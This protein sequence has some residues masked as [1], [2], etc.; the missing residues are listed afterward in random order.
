MGLS[1]LLQA[2]KVHISQPQ[3]ERPKMV[4]FLA[5]GGLVESPSTVLLVAEAEPHTW[6][7]ITPS[8]VADWPARTAIAVASTARQEEVAHGAGSRVI[9]AR[10]SAGVR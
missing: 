7:E 4:R 3:A 8:R 1:F 6:R 5:K 2:V 10:F 9:C